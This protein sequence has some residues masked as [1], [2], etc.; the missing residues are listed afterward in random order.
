MQAHRLCRSLHS[1]NQAG[2]GWVQ[3]F[4]GAGEFEQGVDEVGHLIHASAHF[5]IQLL[6]LCGGQAAIAEKL[7]IGDHGGER[8]AKIVG[9]G[10]GHASDRR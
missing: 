8:V 9:D 6:A 10:T 3:R 7:R 1:L 5:L 4:S 2:I